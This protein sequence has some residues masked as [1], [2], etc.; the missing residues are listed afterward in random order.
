M[1][2][3]ATIVGVIA[4][5]GGAGIVTVAAADGVFGGGDSTP[6]ASSPAFAA[7]SNTETATAATTRPT[8]MSAATAPADPTPE[9]PEVQYAREMGISVEAA[10]EALAMQSKIHVGPLYVEGR[11]AAIWTTPKPELHVVAWYTGGDDGLE[12]ARE[13]AKDIPVPVEFRTDAP[14][15]EAGFVAVAAEAVDSLGENP[16]L[17]GSG[18]FPTRGAIVIHLQPYSRLAGK[19]AETEAMLEARFGVP[20]EV[21]TLDEVAGDD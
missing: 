18:F 7:P 3:L 9:P 20:F 16:G 4:V 15:D 12:S 1:N 8:T 5:V 2:R 10:G 19:E 17:A 14:Y 13:A 11:T 6:R 21:Q